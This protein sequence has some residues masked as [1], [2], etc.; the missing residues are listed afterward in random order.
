MNTQKLSTKEGE[1]LWQ[2]A[3]KHFGSN[4]KEDNR[5]AIQVA[6]QLIEQGPVDNEMLSTLNCLIADTYAKLEEQ[7]AAIEFYKKALEINPNNALAGSNLG[8]QYLY[9]KKDYS[10]AVQILQQTLDRGTSKV[11]IRETTRD[12]LAEAKKMLNG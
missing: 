10:A 12:L 2:A 8:F 3:V 9:S 6:Q 1:A 11:F 7:D 4:N 5:K